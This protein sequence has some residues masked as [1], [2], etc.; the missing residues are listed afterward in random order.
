MNHRK[1]ILIYTK[2]LISILIFACPLKSNSKQ[3]DQFSAPINA[4]ADLEWDGQSIILEYGGKIIL[5]A[6]IENF[7]EEN[8]FS[9]NVVNN[10]G[11]INQV[12]KWTT[13]DWENP[14]KLVGYISTSGEGFPCEAD[15]KRTGPDIVRHSS[16]LSS[17]LLNR[18]VYDR[19]NDWALSLDFPSDVKI[20]PETYTE[21]ENTFR[22]EITGHDIILRFRPAF[23]NRHRGLKYF[24]PW[25][26]RVWQDPVVGWCSWFAYFKDVSEK[27][28]KNAADV[29]SEELSPFGYEYIQMDDGFQQE[30]A[31]TPET[32]LI[33][34]EKFPSGLDNLSK[35]ILDKGLKPGIW[36]YTSFHQEDY[37]SANRDMFVSDENGDPAYGNWV[38]Y[39]MDGTNPEVFSRIIR[40]LY[41]GFR[42]MGWRYFKVDALRH[43]RYEGYNSFSDYF[44]DKNVDLVETYRTF[45]KTIRDEI[46]RDNFMLGCW[47][48]RPELTGIIDG[49]RIGGDGFGYAGLVQYN[50]F[51]NVVWRNDPDHIELSREEA[52]RSCMITSLT[53]SLFMLTDK[54]EVYKTEII[55]P[56]KRAVPVLFTLPGQI[57]DVDPSRSMHLEMVDSEVSG[58][59]IRWID[60]DRIPRCDLYLLEINRD[61]ENWMV[62]GRTGDEIPEIYFSHLGLPDSNEYFVFEFWSKELLGSF[63]N[64]FYTGSIDP[65]YNCQL[66]SIR[67]RV[68][69]PQIIATNRHITCGGFEL[70]IVDWDNSVLSGTSAIV[71]ND[72]YVIYL[73]EPEGYSYSEFICDNAD[74]VSNTR[75]GIMRVIGIKSKAN[76]K[77]N[78]SV[79]YAKN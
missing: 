6:Q 62:L 26:Y 16:G 23:Y 53:G 63:S 38:G 18:A 41:A 14:L 42:E 30:P 66:F 46:G 58:D 47:G 74:V 50:S 43:L 32:W 28:M 48:I 68:D 60:S 70:E 56:A 67:K 71:G 72:T 27:K 8:D 17:S 3:I 61:F 34:N 55:E 25:E 2:F 75:D 35:Y 57:F 37:V 19:R 36:T 49:C 40:P 79:V 20:I 73:S 22:I 11:V 21:N 54:P 31:G 12:M 76:T 78:W 39:I 33:P 5:R 4:A 10:G 77:V 1:S 52:Y 59:E 64:K 51:N 29:I 45:V 7:S 13:R 69:Y 44:K 65:L 24:K 15:R 9:K